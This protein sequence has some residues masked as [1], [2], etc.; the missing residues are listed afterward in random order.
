MF[1]SGRQAP[2]NAESE[3]DMRRPVVFAWIIAGA[4]GPALGCNH[5]NRYQGPVETVQP[6]LARRCGGNGAVACTRKAPES[7][8]L[9]RAENGSGGMASPYRPM[10]QPRQ[11]PE[12]EASA[13]ATEVEVVRTVQVE[14]KPETSFAES[15]PVP[16]PNGLDCK[17]G[18]RRRVRR[19]FNDLTAHPAFAHDTHYRWLVGVVRQKD[20]ENWEIRYA[21]VDDEDAYGGHLPLVPTGAMPEL[22]NGQLVRVEG[23]V[24]EG[25]ERTTYQAQTIRLLPAQP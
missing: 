11:M 25:N 2:A 6:P 13:P 8:N 7:P 24:Q 19:S 22:K 16:E 17:P 4:L 12:T 15:R 5:Q 23:H 14:P 9:A 20:S 10:A 3:D 18:D 21:S 1:P